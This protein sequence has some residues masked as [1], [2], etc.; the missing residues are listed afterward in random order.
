MKLDA[1]IHVRGAYPDGSGGSGLLHPHVGRTGGG[2]HPSARSGGPGLYGLR[3]LLV[4]DDSVM[5]MVIEDM[6]SELGCVVVDVASAVAQALES[7]G[8]GGVDAA[9]LDASVDGESVS[10][11]ADALT[12]REVPFVF[13]TGAEPAPLARY[14]RSRILAKPYDSDSLARTLAGCCRE[15]SERL[16]FT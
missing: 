8:G 7:V 2:L 10:P 1:R 3:I 4:Q 15:A 9:I 13:T 16:R 12:A 11:V 5:A 6:L 14:P